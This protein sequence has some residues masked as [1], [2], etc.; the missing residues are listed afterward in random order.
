MRTRRNFLEISKMVNAI[1]T[2]K[3]QQQQRRKQTVKQ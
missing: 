3:Q 1:Q 2:N